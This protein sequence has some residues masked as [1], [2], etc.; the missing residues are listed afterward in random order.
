MNSEINWHFLCRDRLLITL[1]IPLQVSRQI[2]TIN[3]VWSP[4]SDLGAHTALIRL[5]DSSVTGTSP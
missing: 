4:L 3:M 1:A 5:Q 2:S